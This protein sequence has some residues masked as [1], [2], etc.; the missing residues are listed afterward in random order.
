MLIPFAI[1][2]S[3]AVY[4]IQSFLPRFAQKLLK[5]Y[6][7]YHMWCEIVFTTNHHNSVCFGDKEIFTLYANDSPIFLDYSNYPAEEM[8]KYNFTGFDRVESFNVMHTLNSP[9]Y[10]WSHQQGGALDKITVVS[11]ETCWFPGFVQSE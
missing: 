9:V 8:A 4:K 11:D 5:F 2:W 3:F 10:L 7:Q 1:C 6:L